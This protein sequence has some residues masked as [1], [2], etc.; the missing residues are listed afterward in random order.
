MRAYLPASALL[1][2]SIIAMAWLSFTPPRNGRPVAA[3]FAPWSPWPETFRR[4]ADTGAA[5]VRSGGLANI[6]VVQSD[7]HDLLDRLHA[8]GAW[9][10]VDPEALATCLGQI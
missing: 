2:F 3:V 4:A 1:V 7:T 6:V 8:A 5:I 10:V 9:L